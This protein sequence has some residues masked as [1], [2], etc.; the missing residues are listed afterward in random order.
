M[1]VGYPSRTVLRDVNLDFARGTVTG[2]LGANGSGKSTLL[3]TLLGILPPS[4]GE[5]CWGTSHRQRGV[6]GYVPQQ[7][8]LDPIFPLT[9]LEVALQGTCGRVRPG[10]RVPETERVWAV[11]CLGQV[12]AGD[13]LSR[14]F[15]ELSG[16]QQQRVLI[17]RAL[18]TRPDLLVLDEPANGLDG[19]AARALTD[20]LVRL[21][22]EGSTIVM[23]THDFAAVQHHADSV[24]WLHD[25]RAEQGPAA[26]LLTRERLEEVLALALD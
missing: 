5:F 24:V 26:A 20:L 8:G 15:A 3:R 9:S 19:G 4:A 13:L 14:S 25:G 1:S 22:A 7:E 16:G 2:V 17:A 21:R 10:H 6:I 23:V 12:G 11:E 18:V